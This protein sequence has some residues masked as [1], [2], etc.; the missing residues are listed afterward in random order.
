MT[1]FFDPNKR[2]RVGP[3]GPFSG[4]EPAV[5]L[6]RQPQ[7]G[8]APVQAAPALYRAGAAVGATNQALHNV[9]GGVTGATDAYVDQSAD[10]AKLGARNFMRGVSGQP[11]LTALPPPAAPNVAP[12]SVA[13]PASPQLVIPADH[14][15]QVASQLIAQGAAPASPRGTPIAVGGGA[16]TPGAPVLKSPTAATAPG[17][18]SGVSLPGGRT[19]PY[20]AMV[21]G[22]PTFSDGSGGMP[23][24]AAS[25]P[26]TIS[27]DNIGALGDRLNVVPATAFTN[28]VDTGK[29][30]LT[31]PGGGK[32]GISPQQSSDAR[33]AEVMG[34]DWR[35]ALGTAAS[36]LQRSAGAASSVLQ[37][38]SAL[39]GLGALQQSA[40]RDAGLNTQGATELQRQTLLNQGQQAAE[41]TRG[42]FGLA[43]TR[44]RSAGQLA[45]TR[46]RSAGQLENTDLAGQYAVAGAKARNTSQPQLTSKDYFNNINKQMGAWLTDYNKQQAL[47]PAN[48]QKPPPDDLMAEQRAIIAKSIGLPVGRDKKSGQRVM[49][50]DGKWVA[51]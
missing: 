45:D 39:E 35:T 32:F 30:T 1:L 11:A 8:G 24:H 26:R 20:G 22:V 12:G 10:N 48:Q 17:I 7:A 34:G 43:D 38:K 4:A 3:V 46:L 14:W 2:R 5:A 21:N 44:A 40:S 29:P 49:Q 33:L 19:L 47:L 15:N 50:I 13:T 27:Q 16:A 37:R 28:P 41:N 25:I 6:P 31:P 51:L 9:A 23:G 18:D 36:N 42:Q